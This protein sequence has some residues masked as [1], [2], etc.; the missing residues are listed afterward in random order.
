METKARNGSVV[1]VTLQSFRSFICLFFETQFHF[2]LTLM[3]STQLDTNMTDVMLSVDGGG[4]S[5]AAKTNL[6]E[7]FSFLPSL[8]DLLALIR[9]GKSDDDILEKVQELHKKFED[10][11]VLLRHDLP[12]IKL[13]R[14]E[15]QQQFNVL[16]KKLEQQ[17]AMIEEYKRMELFQ[18]E[19]Q[20]ERQPP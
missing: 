9:D 8:A 7:Q 15:Q 18:R 11:K 17:M 10:A 14:Q 5:S 6:N 3:E 1:V 13:S 16:T 2:H 4:A 20:Q 19:A 12:G